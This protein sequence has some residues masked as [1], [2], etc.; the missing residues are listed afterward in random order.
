[1]IGV[2]LGIRKRLFFLT[3]LFLIWGALFVPFVKANAPT[4]Q[5][6]SVCQLLIVFSLVSSV[7]VFLCSWIGLRVADKTRLEMPILNK[8]EKDDFVVKFE[9]KRLLIVSVMA[10]VIFG[11]VASAFSNYL[12]IPN[13]QGNFVER[14]STTLFAA[15]VPEVV[16]HLFVMSGL[17]FLVKRIWI[18]IFVSSV[19]FAILHGSPSD[20]PV[21]AT[22]FIYGLNFT[23][24]VLTG[25]FYSRFG[26][27][28]AMLTHAVSH[29]IVVGI[30]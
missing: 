13:N 3:F 18:A 28:S 30:N 26:F 21:T 8:W 5:Q 20:I 24:S 25:W 15:V 19:L 4:S 14:I 10:G 22:I 9:T 1:M 23:L 6:T 29:L 17:F 7:V 2:F 16:I 12:G 27:E 11:L